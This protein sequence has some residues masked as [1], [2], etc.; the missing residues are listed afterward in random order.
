MSNKTTNS[1]RRL[2][3]Q[4]AEDIGSVLRKN[5]IEQRRLKTLSADKKQMAN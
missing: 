4:I 3:T 5:I 2:W 1:K